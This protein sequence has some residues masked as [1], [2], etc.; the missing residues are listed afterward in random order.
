MKEY[1]RINP[2]F[3]KALPLDSIFLHSS[4]SL[5]LFG[6]G[7]ESSGFVTLVIPYKVPGYDVN[8]HF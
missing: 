5:P 1:A 6:F 3:L 7:F 8:S 4:T 2:T